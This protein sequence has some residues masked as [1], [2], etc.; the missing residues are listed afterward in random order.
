[1]AHTKA[2]GSTKLGRDSR[3]KRLGVKVQDGQPIGL[4]QIIIRQ[5]GSKYFEGA[6]VGRGGD[7]TLFALKPG[8]VKFSTKTKR[9]FDR[10]T[11]KV[12]VVSVL[13]Q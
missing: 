6:N 12:T 3:S 10:S 11:R 13:A 4:S 7:D 8:I 5:R 1:M 9:S 2:G